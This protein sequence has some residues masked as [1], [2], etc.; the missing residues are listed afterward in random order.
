ML[1]P[2]FLPVVGHCGRD[3]FFLTH[4]LSPRSSRSRSPPC[5][6]VL[7]ANVLHPSY[8]YVLISSNPFLRAY[9]YSPCVLFFLPDFL[10]FPFHMSNL[11]KFNVL[12]LCFWLWLD[13]AKKKKVVCCAGIVR[14]DGGNFVIIF[15]EAL[16][17]IHP[18][19]R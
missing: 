4:L 5:A 12:Y 19:K 3:T 16:R 10:S 8:F 11:N 17:S 2:L 9:V 1:P 13:E 15:R 14:W 18:S 6:P 7:A